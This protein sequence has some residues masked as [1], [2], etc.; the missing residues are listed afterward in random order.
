M[1]PRPV[2]AAGTEAASIAVRFRPPPPQAS[3]ALLRVTTAG[4][5]REGEE[6]GPAPPPAGAA[7]PGGRRTAKPLAVVR[8]RARGRLRRGCRR[9]VRRT[10][11]HARGRL[12]HTSGASAGAWA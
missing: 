3:P 5:G 2:E 8:L 4:A 7:P 9:R 10:C 12:A 11:A 6:E 1:G